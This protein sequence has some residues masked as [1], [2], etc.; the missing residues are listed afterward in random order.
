MMM[1]AKNNQGDTHTMSLLR[2]YG[3]RI[4]DKDG[5][6][7]LES[8]EGIKALAWVQEGVERGWYAPHSENMEILDNMELFNNGQ[9]AIYFYNIASKDNFDL[10]ANGF[11]NW[12]TEDGEGICTSFMTGFEVFDNGDDA[13]PAASKAFIQYIYSTEE[14]TNL[15]SANIPVQ[16]SVSEKYSNLEMLNTFADNADK[17]VNFTNNN[18]NWQGTETSVRSVFWP[19]IHDLLSGDVTP[20]ECARGIDEDCNKAIAIGRESS[21]LHE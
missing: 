2:A 15:E 11:A 5:N 10:Q 17:A 7:D 1:Y 20:E 18:P 3:S 13:K 21:K 9:L 19:H 4:F 6:F 12:P 16:K 8:E 14:W